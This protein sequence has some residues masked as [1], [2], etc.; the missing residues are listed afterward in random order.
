MTR[1][2]IP[3]IFARSTAFAGI[4]AVLSG[5]GTIAG[6][7]PSVALTEGSQTVVAARTDR[8]SLSNLPFF[9][10]NAPTSGEESF[11]SASLG[12]AA[13][14]RVASGLAIPRG[15]GFES[16]GKP[17]TVKGRTYR[18]TANPEKVQYGRASWYGEAF[19]GR[20]TANGEIYDMNH[21]TAAHKT[22]PLP[23]YARVTNVRNGKSVV[24]RVND[25]GPFSNNRVIDLSKRAAFLLDYINQGTA[26]VKVE[27]LGR[28]PL[29]G[30]DDEFLLASYRGAPI[31]PGSTIAAPRVLMAANAQPSPERFGDTQ[32]ADTG[33]L[34]RPV[35]RPDLGT[36]PLA[37]AAYADW[38]IAAA[39]E[40]AE[41]FSAFDSDDGWK[42][43]SR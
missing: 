29:H 12:V 39:F 38:R 17:Y 25:R 4:C 43:A 8:L 33:K 26:E 37:L 23:S 40:P 22:M 13:S 27:Y 30:Q 21:L 36:G 34:P 15:G 2:V 32:R 31:A 9:T 11:S 35:P 24:V 19:H 41:V 42:Q 1:R 5:C 14:P 3:P 20:K 18:P 10:R 16:V 6:T 28:A 7:T